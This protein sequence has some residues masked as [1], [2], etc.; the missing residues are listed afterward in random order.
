MNRIDIED[1]AEFRQGRKFEQDVARHY[2]LRKYHVERCYLLKDHDGKTKAPMLEGPYAGFR[3]PDL[4]VMGGGK[5]SWVECKE[6][7]KAD[8]TRYTNQYEHGIGQRCYRD[9]L[10][11]QEISGLAVYL[12]V[13]EWSHGL[14]RIASLVTLGQPRLY[15]G[16]KMDAG[17]MAF[18]PQERFRLIGTYQS[19]PDQFEFKLPRNIQRVRS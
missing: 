10:K 12:C 15:N 7:E 13:G 8:W 9:Y 3:L 1:T 6:K 19:N 4:K 14:I 5:T 11:V 16:D 17:G 2:L 18:W